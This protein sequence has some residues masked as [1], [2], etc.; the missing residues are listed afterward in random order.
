MAKK[1]E[2]KKE[3]EEQPSNLKQPIEKETNPNLEKSDKPK[4]L[5]PDK[6]MDL[7]KI[8]QGAKDLDELKPLLYRHILTIAQRNKLGDKYHILFLYEPNSSIEQG[9]VD[10]IYN[11]IPDDNKKPIL[12]VIHNHGGR[13]EPAYLIS[14]TCKELSSKF[15]VAIP[16]KAKSAATLISLGGHEIHMGPMSE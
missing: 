10:K 11:A 9:M 16:R 4:E 5:N 7:I 12:L 2:T 14:K 15:I 1:S 6:F 3:K 8:I 13:I